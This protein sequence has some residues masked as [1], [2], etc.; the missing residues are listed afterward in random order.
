MSYNIEINKPKD[1][2]KYLTRP[3]AY[4]I[5]INDAGEIAVVKTKT[6]FFLPG[7]GLGDKET[8]EACLERE[9]LEEIGLKIKV[10]AKLGTVIYSFF[11]TT[12]KINMKS[13]GHFYKC[14][15][16]QKINDG[17]EAD[18]RL[19]WL[20]AT[21][22]M[23]KLYLANQQYA[24]KKYLTGN[25]LWPIANSK[26]LACAKSHA[27]YAINYKKQKSLTRY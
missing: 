5:I 21:E 12:K 23:T 20:P 2:I 27:P 1:N 16:V 18:H 6:G 14:S 10:G 22:A 7:G 11:S 19:V 13:V 8:E 25:G 15:V 26:T 24:V 4:G 9:C 17:T 3:G